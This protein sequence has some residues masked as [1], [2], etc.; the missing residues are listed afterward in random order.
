M[1][2]RGG[3]EILLLDFQNPV[4]LPIHSSFTLK[5]HLPGQAVPCGKPDQAKSCLSSKLLFSSSEEKISFPT[6]RV[7]LKLLN[8]KQGSHTAACSQH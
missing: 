2:W 5:K 3:G 7:L 4:F 6:H 8:T 1:V